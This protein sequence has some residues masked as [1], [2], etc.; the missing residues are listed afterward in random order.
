MGLK[1]IGL[2]FDWR[3]C[4]MSSRAESLE[5]F[6]RAAYG[7]SNITCATYYIFYGFCIEPTHRRTHFHC[8]YVARYVLVA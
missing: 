3:Y 7:F 2:D 6:V 5:C 8:H 4:E 1:S